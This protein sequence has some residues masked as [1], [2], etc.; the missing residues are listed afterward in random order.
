MSLEFRPRIVLPSIRPLSVARPMTPFARNVP[1]LAFESE[2][3]REQ[4]EA[5]MAR[6]FGVPLP[7]GL[8]RK[9]LELDPE[10]LRTPTSVP[11]Y[12]ID[13]CFFPP[14]TSPVKKDGRS[15]RSK[16]A[17]TLLLDSPTHTDGSN[18]TEFSGEDAKLRV[19][20][21]R[22]RLHA[23]RTRIR[24]R[25]LLERLN[26]QVDALQDEFELLNHVYDFHATALCLLR[27]GT[28]HH[29][30]PGEQALERMM[31]GVSATEDCNDDGQMDERSFLKTRWLSHAS[32]RDDGMHGHEKGCGLDEGDEG[33]TCLYGVQFR[34]SGRRLHLGTG[35]STGVAA[36]TASNILDCS[37]EERERMRRERNRLHARRARLRKKQVL[38]ESQQAVYKLQERNDRLRSRLS[39]LVSSIYG[40][41]VCLD[42]P[43]ATS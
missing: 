20:R 12:T 35:T 5:I 38:E 10:S 2:E 14:S 33:C 3:Q 21:E 7:H 39:V 22:N 19:S 6:Y 23:Q 28:S 25:E 11:S 43:G 24:K 40:S 31:D 1:S 8:R 26:E 41:E 17:M 27:L 18:E 13:G 42:D 4:N 29:N 15:C 30:V 16:T 37:K 32:E 9:T 36:T 34:S